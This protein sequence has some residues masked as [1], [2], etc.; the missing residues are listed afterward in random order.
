MDCPQW[1]RLPTSSSIHASGYAVW[2]WCLERKC[3]HRTSQFQHVIHSLVAKLV[4]SVSFYPLTSPGAKRI[5]K[6]YTC[7]HLFG[8]MDI[9]CPNPEEKT[10]NSYLWS[11]L[12]FCH[13]PNS[14]Q[15]TSIPRKKD[16]KWLVQ[17][18]SIRSLR[19]TRSTH[20]LILPAHIHR[21]PLAYQHGYPRPVLRL[22]LL[23]F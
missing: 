22:S 8:I 7:F 20:I 1:L 21:S 19:H 5:E 9:V 14:F 18:S 13:V 6:K 3:C 23:V 2:Q 16:L 15:K 4:L 12:M 10:N 17:L 11:Y